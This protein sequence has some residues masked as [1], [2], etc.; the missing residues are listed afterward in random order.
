MMTIP[1]AAARLGVN[2]QWVWRLVKAG[3]LAG[4]KRGRD[5]L[6]DPESVEKYKNSERKAG[7]RSKSAKKTAN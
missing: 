2:R 7:R 6:I 1:E 3:R 4:E 5:W